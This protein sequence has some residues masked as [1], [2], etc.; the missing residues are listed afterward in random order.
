LKNLGGEIDLPMQ[1]KLL[2]NGL[3]KRTNR[4]LAA[5]GIPIEKE[6]IIPALK[7]G[8]LFPSF[9]PPTYGRGT[10]HE[11]CRWAGID[12]ATVPFI[13][14]N[15]LPPC[16][17]NGLSY[18]ANN[19]LRDAG[20][21]PT[22]RDVIKSL[23]NGDLIPRKRPAGYGKSTHAEICRWAGID[24]KAI[25]KIKSVN[26]TKP[27]TPISFKPPPDFY[28]RFYSVTWTANV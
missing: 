5:A 22:K 6:S 21:L 26:V 12:P 16:L 24:P 13:W 10:H 25:L 28:A 9:W 1:S 27:G 11:V 14:A 23:K 15:K 20:I 18:R 4:C 17:D 7:A 19:C 3:S 2:A 8:K